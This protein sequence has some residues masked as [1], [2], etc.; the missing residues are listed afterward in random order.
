MVVGQIIIVYFGGPVFKTEPLS[1]GEWAASVLIGV[2]TLLWG[3]VI[4]ILPDEI[5]FCFPKPGSRS[6]VP[7]NSLAPPRVD[8]NGNLIDDGTP[9]MSK[10]QLHWA[11]AV[12][13]SSFI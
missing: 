3:F 9:E 5:F 1:G 2:F 8:S 11:A 6:L 4:R 13:P 12:R 7:Q 10:P